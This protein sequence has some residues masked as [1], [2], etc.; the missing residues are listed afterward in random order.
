MKIV[1]VGGTGLIGSKLVTKL[2]QAGEAVVAASPSHGIDAYTGDRLVEA[3]RGADVV[4]DVSNTKHV[5][6]EAARE[7]FT[8]STT[9]LLDAGATAGV[10]HH[11]TLSIVGADRAPEDGYFVAKKA[12]EQLVL[13]SPLPHSLL[14]ATQ[15][16]EFAEQI[17]DWNTTEGTIRLP[18]TS[19]KPVASDD[20][21]QSLFDLVETEPTGNILELGGPEEIGL[22]EFVRRVLL[23]HHDDR[24]IFTDR[25]AEPKG[26]NLRSVALL[27]HD[28]ALVASTTL[29]VWI[30]QRRAKERLAQRS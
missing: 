11:I 24:Y 29:D 10:G 9:N 28:G 22:D 13:A 30:E 4:V 7:F 19:M 3:L 27:P 1:V 14:R 21:V 2:Q 16:F 23:L 12:Q 5:E 15:F 18:A 20:V 25:G 26:F 6:G 8:R 17:A